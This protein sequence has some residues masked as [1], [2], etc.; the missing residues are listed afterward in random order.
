[1]LLTTLKPKIDSSLEPEEPGG[2][3]ALVTNESVSWRDASLSLQRRRRRAT[4]SHRPRSPGLSG[5]RSPQ[6]ACS[7]IRVRV[8]SSCQ[9][10]MMPSFASSSSPRAVDIGRFRVWWRV[11]RSLGPCAYCG[12]TSGG[13]PEAASCSQCSAS[14]VLMPL[15]TKDGTE[16]GTCVWSTG[17]LID[18]AGCSLQPA[19]RRLRRIKPQS[20]KVA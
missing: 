11:T 17:T 5:Q 14:S 8:A 13:G 1:V 3:S 9:W 20:A 19:T 15:Q 10:T 6:V 7:S 4:W 16:A 18:E 12:C 2:P